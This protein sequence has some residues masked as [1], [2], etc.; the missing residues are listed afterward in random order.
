MFCVVDVVYLY[1][2][3]FVV[4][5]GVDEVVYGVGL[6]CYVLVVYVEYV[7]VWVDICF[8]GYVVWCGGNYWCCIGLVEYEYCLECCQ[9]KNEIEV[10]FGCYD[11]DVFLYW[12]GGEFLVV[13][14]GVDVIFVGVEYFYVVVQWDYCY[15]V[16]GIVVCGVFL[17]CLVEVY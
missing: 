7:V 8:C 5:Q 2:E 15:L 14:S 16:F 11:C 10:G 9:C 6:G 3:W 4:E 12:F 13:Q 1:V 17:D